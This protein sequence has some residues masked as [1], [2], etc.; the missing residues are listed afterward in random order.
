MAGFDK[1]GDTTRLVDSFRD[2]II[3]LVEGPTDVD[4]L[5]RMFPGIEAEIRFES[6]GGCKN[7]KK[8]LKERRTNSPRIYGILDRDAL[9]SY[10]QWSEFFEIGDDIFMQTTRANGLYILTRWEIENYLIDPTAVRQLFSAW[11]EDADEDALL[12]RMLETA[13]AELHMTAGCC[14]AFVCEVRESTGPAACA[15]AH[16]LPNLVKAWIEKDFSHAI[17]DYEGH[18]SKILAFDPGASVS[19]RE[20]LVAILR[21]VDGKRFIERLQ[22]R[23]L[24]VNRDPSRQL[25]ENVGRMRHRTDDLFRIL[26]ELREKERV[27]RRGSP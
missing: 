4:F 5:Q 15:D 10:G 24:G 23:W 21:M 22:R 6:V 1:H 17:G 3:I 13:F 8:D 11:K 7:M 2:M 18:L 14:A 25:A 16:A 9:R 19:K 26:E 20:R 27:T 12:D